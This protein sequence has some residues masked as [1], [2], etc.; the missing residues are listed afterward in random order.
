MNAVP[1][2]T[3]AR[4]QTGPKSSATFS[5]LLC[6]Q[7]SQVATDDSGVVPRVSMS[8]FLKCAWS[9]AA[10]GSCG[11]FFFSHFALCPRSVRF[12]TSRIRNL[13]ILAFELLCRRA[14]ASASCLFASPALPFVLG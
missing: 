5:F 7:P 10:G 4:N 13:L 9:Q 6:Q 2:V 1:E 8:A 11:W 12:C 3:Q 14:K